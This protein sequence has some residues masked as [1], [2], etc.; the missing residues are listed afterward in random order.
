MKPRITRIAR[1]GLLSLLLLGG[2]APKPAPASYIY[3]VSYTWQTG[4]TLHWNSV[5]I[6]RSTPITNQGEASQILGEIQE[7]FGITNAV[8]VSFSRL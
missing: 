1:M 8:L 7:K 3:F 4:G 2:C 5:D 6:K